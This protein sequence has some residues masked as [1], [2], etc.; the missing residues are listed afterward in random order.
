MQISAL[1][2]KVDASHIQLES[3]ANNKAL[4]QEDKI[5]EASRQFEAVLLRQFLSESQK[6]VITSEFTDNST[7]AGIYQDFIT[8]QLAD[9]LSRGGGIGLAKSFERQLTHPK[10]HSASAQGDI[11]N[12]VSAAP[13]K[14]SA[15]TAA[16]GFSQQLSHP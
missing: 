1:Q 8:N 16:V 9:S 13:Q 12:S 4:S 11:A 5:A 2:Q 7:A 15:A 6:P 14:N 10:P 3:L